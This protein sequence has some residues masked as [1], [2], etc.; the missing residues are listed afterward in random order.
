MDNI[1]VF[2]RNAPLPTGGYIEQADG[3]SWMAMYALNLMR[4]AT[5]LS[6]TNRT[7]V[8]IAAKFFDHF[9]YIAGAIANIGDENANLWDDEDAFFYDRLQLPDGTTRKL[10]VRS[11]V[12]LIPMFA[13]EVLTD[14]E[15]VNSPIFSERLKWFYDNRPDL[16]SLVS[17][18]YEPNPAGMRL[19]SLLRGHRM[20]ML[21]K[22]MLDETEFLSDYGIRSVSKYHLN[23]PFTIWAGGQMFSVKYLPAES[24][25][26]L[27][28]G[29]SNWRGPIWLP[30]NYL[31]VESLQRF[32]QYFG[33]DFKVECPTGS[34]NFMTLREVAAELSRRLSHIFL[35][36][37][38]GRRPVYGNNQ[39]LQTDENFKDYVLF[40]EYFDGDTGR[41]LGASHQTGWT[42]LIVAALAI[43]LHQNL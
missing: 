38:D 24:D 32:Y 35:R 39:R 19:I 14:D 34:G 43:N 28:G 21:L 29:N 23:N 25:S 31:L 26:G 40:H 42:G 8:N 20:K 1:G 10:K 17:R 7:Y 41:G 13:V 18:W 37:A 2:D 5:E 16:S 33:D 6:K 4:I 15:V 11:V 9:M 27:F 36:G 22:R 3:T 30:I 12:G